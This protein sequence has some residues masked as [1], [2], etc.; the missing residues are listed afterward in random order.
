MSAP[1]WLVTGAGSG[2]GRTL[3]VALASSGCRVLITSRDRGHLEDTARWCGAGTGVIPADLSDP[4]SVAS[5]AASVEV[6]LAGAPLAG[7]VHAA[8]VMVWSSPVASSGWSL[9]P[10]VNAIGPWTLTQLL[11]PAL[12]RDTGSR[13]L[14]VAGA[15]VTLQGVRPRIEGWKGTQTGRGLALALEAAAAKVWMA[16]SL[17]RRWAGRASA[18][19]FHPGYIKSH[20]A[21]ALPFPLSTLGCL[22]QP[23]LATRCATGEFLAL[24][25][26]ALALSGTLVAGRRAV[27]SCPGPEDPGA[28]DAWLTEL[29]RVEQDAH[30]V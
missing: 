18:L 7:I 11:E 12:L 24:A 30:R 10:A 9:V 23:F 2:V 21:D 5:L 1:V 4:S 20:L 16:R 26:G 3:A 25:P 8:G 15:P 17:H 28:E 14:F 22:A 13:V 19:A 27:P 29:D 6:H